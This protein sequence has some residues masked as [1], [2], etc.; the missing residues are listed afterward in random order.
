MKITKFQDMNLSAKVLKSITEMGYVEP[1]P[2]QSSTIMKI[3]DGKDV[4]GQAQTGTGK[5]AAFGIPII[6]KID[7]PDKCIQAVV[8][9]PTRELAIQV[10][11]ELQKIAKYHK[12]IRIIPIYGGQSIEHQI[13]SLKS[14][15]H[16]A[17][18]TPG[19]LMDHMERRTVNLSKVK[20]AV[21][22]ETDEMLNMG[23]YDDMLLI[24][25]AINH[26]DRQTIMF[27]ATMPEK[28][29]QLA[30]KFQKNP[31]MI[32]IQHKELTVPSIKQYYYEI[33]EGDKSALLTRLI[34]F[35]SPKLALV[36]ANTKTGTEELKDTIHAAGYSVKALHGDMQQNRRTAVMK[37]FRDRKFEILIATD[38]AARGIDV[39]DI[40]IVFNYDLPQDEE[41]YVHR[42]GRTARAGKDGM[43]ISFVTTREFRKLRDIERFSK[44]KIERKQ[45]PTNVEIEST[46]N[47]ILVDEIKEQ[48]EA[49]GL[50]KYS[51]LISESVPEYTSIEIAAALMKMLVDK[52]GAAQRKIDM[53]SYDKRGEESDD[54]M[55]EFFVLLGRRDKF[56]SKPELIDFVYKKT[57]VS[58]KYIQKINI[59]EKFSFL[60][61]PAEMASQFHEALSGSTFNNKKI[62]VERSNK[63]KQ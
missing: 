29:K 1:S 46:R 10:A 61:V 54:D 38:V 39:D 26:P 28:I 63:K 42:I 37:E 12:D 11:G 16:I 17:I 25:K 19:R 40:D 7:V 44:A 14:G 50:D 59:H 21:L 49:G 5:T 31:E 13:Q 33:R 48:V 43:A 30:H 57:N 53:K 22:D 47:K 41:Y 58:G 20:I 34:D 51:A 56:N 6:E 55:V 23:F 36:F 32:K 62:I 8:L 27:S 9:T 60:S 15:V 2:I 24:L 45:I 4:I 18:C 3:I 35:Y 52:T